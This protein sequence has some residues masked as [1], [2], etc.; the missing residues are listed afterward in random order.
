MDTVA[1]NPAFGAG[2]G[3]I[4]VDDD[5]DSYE[6]SRVPSQPTKVPNAEPGNQTVR[7]RGGLKR[8]GEH[9]KKRG[10]RTFGLHMLIE[11][12]KAAAAPG[13]GVGNETIASEEVEASLRSEAAL[14]F[15]ILKQGHAKLNLKGNFSSDAFNS[16]MDE[17][18]GLLTMFT[19]YRGFL[20][21]VTNLEDKTIFY[22]AAGVYGVNALVRLAIG[23]HRLFPIY[24]TK[25]G[26]DEDDK[27][28]PKVPY[29]QLAR[30]EDT[31]SIFCG[32]WLRLIAGI[33][34]IMIE[35]VAGI[36]LLD[37]AYEP[38]PALTEPEKAALA[39]AKAKA[40]DSI[41]EAE[42]KI[43]EARTKMSK[44]ADAEEADMEAAKDRDDE[45]SRK[46]AKAL[47]DSNREEV[48]VVKK[49]AEYLKASS[50]IIQ[51]Q[52]N[53]KLIQA[54]VDTRT[55]RFFLEKRKLEGTEMV[56][57][58][59]A[60][61]ED[62]PELAIAATFA[63][64]GGLNAASQADISLF[65][66]SQVISLFHAFKCFWSFWTLRKVVR[67][68]KFADAENLDTQ[69]KYF[70][71]RPI[72]DFGIDGQRSRSIA[73]KIVKIEPLKLE[74]ETKRQKWDAEFKR[75][76]KAVANLTG[77]GALKAQIEKQKEAEATR[78]DEVEEF[79]RIEKAV[80]N[81]TGGGALKAQI[82]K[83]KKDEKREG[84]GERGKTKG[85]IYRL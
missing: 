57:L 20:D 5:E 27:G 26:G 60:I 15:V 16:L 12:E 66:T 8:G 56:E 7:L 38:A 54:E 55:R 70:K 33:M 69:H 31:G 42:A 71:E 35:P 51:E 10:Q 50:A 48:V 41:I 68:A 46:L 21:P 17:T 83:Q 47:A 40:S 45:E 79:K 18:T 6:D 24:G 29:T 59:M 76:E 73:D 34:L 44:T 28:E 14:S 84:G 4:H 62:I 36:R 65:V 23:I 64:K 72:E 67:G 85:N 80:A 58:V 49:E 78:R 2:G 32:T 13:A 39:E 3:Y 11:T 19:V 1:V 74:A 61:F 30:N 81:L 52:T 63:A 22:A 43:L 37:S 53:L 25:N 82:E 77:G 9:R 75:I